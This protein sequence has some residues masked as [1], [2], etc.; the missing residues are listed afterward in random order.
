MLGSLFKINNKPKSKT[1]EKRKRK[2]E[3][4]KKGKNFLFQLFSC[5]EILVKRDQDLHQHSF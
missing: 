3:K 2:K 5:M 4:E 1:K